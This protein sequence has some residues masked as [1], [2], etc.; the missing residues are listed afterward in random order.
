MDFSEKVRELSL[1]VRDQLT[2]IQTEEATK[3]ALIMPF[4]SVLGYNVFNPLEVTP[5]LHA[6]VGVKKGEKV[7]YAVLQDGKPIMLF[8]CKWH[9]TDL[10]KEHAS[11]LYRYF[12][13]TEA[14]F[15]VLTNGVQYQFYTDLE[16]PNRM[17]DKP[18][19]TFDLL[20]YR[21]HELD[22]LRKFTKAAF[23]VDAIL[24]TASE[25]KYTN[26][27]KRVLEQEFKQPS[28]AL[29]RHF[30]T[31]VYSGRITPAVRE[32]F[33]ETTQRAFRQFVNERVNQRLQSALSA[34]THMEQVP[35]ETETQEVS[36]EAEE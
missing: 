19:F 21:E 32:Q 5:E 33:A 3:N 18:F 35:D 1:R 31:L 8:E 13:V 26:A 6:D 23:D 34:E 17:D 20:S 28:D 2:F 29:V 15:S 12:S 14:R 24:A 11:Q 10:K 9:G 30:A 16:A 4:I 22:E 7:D 36:T 25:L 27:I